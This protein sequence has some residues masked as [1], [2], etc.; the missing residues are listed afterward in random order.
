MSEFDF[1]ELLT[2]DK[3][4]QKTA[5]IPRE[6]LEVPPEPT[7]KPTRASVTKRRFDKISNEIQ[8]IKAILQEVVITQEDRIWNKIKATSTAEELDEFLAMVLL[9]QHIRAHYTKTGR[10]KFK[11]IDFEGLQTVLGKEQFKL[12]WKRFREM[13]LLVTDKTTKAGRVIYQLLEVEDD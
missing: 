4:S 5:E 11:T 13:G 7:K 8:E 3:K 2:K 9:D 1:S 12:V 6:I 10:S